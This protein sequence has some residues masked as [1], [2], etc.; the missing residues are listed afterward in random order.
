MLEDY[1]TAPWCLRRLGRGPIAS[2]INGLAASLRERG[3]TRKRIRWVVCLTGKFSRY[4]EAAGV[5]HA[6]DVD[7]EL[8]ARFLQALPSRRFRDAP[9]AM[10]HM[11]EQLRHDGV[12]VAGQKVRVRQDRFAPLLTR[13]DHYL[14]A[15]RGLPSPTRQDYSRGARLLLLWLHTHHRARRLGRLRGAEVIEF[16][17]DHVGT[18]SSGAW[19]NRLTSQTRLF[20][21]FLRWEGTIDRDLACVIPKLPYW[22]LSS[23]PRHLPWERV[24][25][26]INSIDTG[27]PQGLRDRAVLLLCAVLGMRA[28]EVRTLRLTDIAWRSAE[29]NLPQTKSFRARLLPLPHEVGV[30][31][32]DY[33]LHGRPRVHAPEVILRHDAPIGPLSSPSAV[34]RIV[35]RSVRRAGIVVPARPGAHMLRH[36]LATRLVNEG[37]PIK[38]IADLLGH[39]SINT[40]A[41]YS[42][43][44]RTR[45]ATVALPLPADA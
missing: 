44:D 16:I 36:S 30:A 38:Q 12:I 27:T 23:V 15:V 19:R 3:Y 43:V 39:I 34:G 29:I 2:H 7:E 45:L 42:K 32:K 26:L 41:I 22:R 14:S 5:D 25:A 8:V 37:V 9:R 21:G 18:Y 35:A 10:H 40:T 24:R 33:L 31:L 13:Y 20:I 4:A 6:S 1:F 11:L 17:S 28:G